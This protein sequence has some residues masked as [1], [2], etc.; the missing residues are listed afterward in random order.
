MADIVVYKSYVKNTC[1]R[2]M[3]QPGR[4]GAGRKMLE[5]EPPSN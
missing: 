1:C 2:S 3:K 5:R 4:S